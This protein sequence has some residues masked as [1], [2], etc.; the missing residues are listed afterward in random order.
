MDC[1]K[2]NSV[3]RQTVSACLKQVEE[4]LG[5]NVHCSSVAIAALHRLH[6]V[7]GFRA[8]CHLIS[9]TGKS[10]KSDSCTK[11]EYE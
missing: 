4:K 8:F 6:N 5:Y 3:Q 1:A 7:C 10:Q 11:M 9:A 2:A